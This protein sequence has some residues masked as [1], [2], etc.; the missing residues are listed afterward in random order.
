VTVHIYTEA[1]SEERITNA[2]H[3]GKRNA[4][5]GFEML[6]TIAQAYSNPEERDAFIEGYLKSMHSRVTRE[7][8][9]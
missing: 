6:W 3:S 8:L 1:P 7:R 2:Y 4:Q 5:A 9:K